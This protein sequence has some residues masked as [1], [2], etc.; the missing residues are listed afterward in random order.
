MPPDIEVYPEKF[1]TREHF[2]IFYS[3]KHD[4]SRFYVCF[5]DAEDTK[6]YRIITENWTLCR[7]IILIKFS[8]LRSTL[9]TYTPEICSWSS[10]SLQWRLCSVAP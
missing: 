5:E 6:E 1:D 2:R 10:S 8:N 4:V 9:L 3:D 7:A